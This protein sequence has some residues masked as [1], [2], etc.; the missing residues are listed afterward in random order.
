MYFFILRHVMFVL[1]EAIS[2]SFIDLV[3]TSGVP[4]LLLLEEAWNTFRRSPVPSLVLPTPQELD[5]IDVPYCP[6][7][8]DV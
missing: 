5:H 3:L 6:F 2:D 4:S 8:M 1:L 7:K